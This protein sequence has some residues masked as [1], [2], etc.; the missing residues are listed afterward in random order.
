L[1]Q[2][3]TAMGISTLPPVLT[4]DL[5]SNKEFL[6]ALYHILMNVHLVTGTLTC[7]VTGLQFPVE[8]E[9][10]NMVIEDGKCERLN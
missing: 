10:P 9:I 5:A 8:N 7:P 4:E 6:A 1:I 2:G 3:A